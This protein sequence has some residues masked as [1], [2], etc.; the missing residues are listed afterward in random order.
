MLPMFAF[1]I[2]QVSKN[3]ISPQYAVPSIESDSLTSTGKQRQDC[4]TWSGSQIN[5]QIKVKFSYI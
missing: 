5:R 1:E 4:T 2:R 3:S